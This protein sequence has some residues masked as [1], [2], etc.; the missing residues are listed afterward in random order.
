[1]IREAIILA[2]GMGTRL[3]EALPG[4][5]KCMAPVNNIPFI[6]YLI[7]YLLNRGIEHFIFALGHLHE[8][9]EEH[10]QKA[11]PALN[12]SF[13]VESQPLGTGGALLLACRQTTEKDVLVMNGDTLY[14]IDTETLSSFHHQHRAL[15]TLALKPMKDFDRYG[16][17]ETDKD[18][19]I[20]S[21]LEKK[22]YK[23]GMI[24]G[25]VYAIHVPAFL[26]LGL[27]EKCSFEK[28][29]LERYSGSEKMMGLPDEG[30]FI[31]IGIPEDYRRANTELPERFPQIRKS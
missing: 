4:L 26:A 6:D 16:V 12:V 30:Y 29:F 28:D 15:C 24:N 7:S 27:P 25:G 22:P 11:Y 21:F 14:A 9:I 23:S 31:D 19:H 8:S 10:I 18:G 20:R 17:V 5:P 1:M 13:S 3:R 2:G